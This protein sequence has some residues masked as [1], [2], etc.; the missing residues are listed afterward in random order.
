MD[1]ALIAQA[2]ETIA[3]NLADVQ[4]RINEAASRVNR[5]PATITLVAISKT[6][7]GEHVVAGYNLGLRVFGENRVEEAIDKIPA[8]AQ[9]L[10]QRDEPAPRWHMVGHLQSRKSADALDLFELIHSVDSAK[11]ARRLSRQAGERHR[12]ARI[13]L[14]FNVSGEAAKYGFAAA[15]D[16]LHREALL[17]QMAEIAALPHLDILGLMTMAPLVPSAEQAR[18]YFQRLAQW[19]QTLRK[20]FHN[21]AWSELSMGM[22]NDFGVAIEEGATMIRLGRAVF[23]PRSK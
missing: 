3:S 8:V 11:L 9:A 19:Q 13:L 23:G 15:P 6:F 1:E 16:E 10:S 20:R 18:P 17:Q 21:H 12:Q 14:E 5:D 2:Q 7:S 4:R 22:T